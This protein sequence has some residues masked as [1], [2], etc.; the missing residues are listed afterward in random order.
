VEFEDGQKRQNNVYAS[1]YFDSIS[2]SLS[3]ILLPDAA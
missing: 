3:V 2:A 1:Q